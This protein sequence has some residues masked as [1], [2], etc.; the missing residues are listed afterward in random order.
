M[1]RALVLAAGLALALGEVNATADQAPSDPTLKA[2]QQFLEKRVVADPDDIIAQN[3]LADIYLQRLSENGDY[4]WLRRAGEAARRSLASV[5]A[6]QNATGL[7]VQ[8]RV[9]YESHH[10]AAARDLASALIKIEPTKSRGFALLG[11]ALL[12]YGDLEE[13]AA[14][15]E[16]MRERKAAPV[17][18]EA[19]LGHLEVARGGRDAARVH[20]ERAVAAARQLSPVNPE[21][22]AS[23]LVQAGELEFDSGKWE[24]AEKNYEAALAERPAD[25]GALVRLAEL[26]AA[27]AK[28]EEAISLFER[29]ISQKPRPEFWH[30]LGDVFAAAGKPEIAGQWRARAREAYLKNATEG[31]AHYFHH[32]AE[33][34]SDTEPNPEEA[35]K[36]ARRDAELRHTAAVQDALAW[37]LYRGGD[38]KQAVSV[39]TKVL[40][41]GV[42]DAEILAHAGTIFLAAGDSARGNEL[43]VAAARV[44]PRHAEFHVHR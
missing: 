9:E 33:F 39:A 37:A 41:G 13:A 12:E 40:A 24:E 8:A 30:A 35:L 1:C 17:E 10:F 23:C 44:N 34:F 3:R 38:L 27:Q 25:V 28:Y 29:A 31:N 42:K 36:W 11:D 16:K 19:R 7:Y 4:E 43:L 22:T 14:A 5:P 18:I 2:V 20:L 26:R 32:L 21:I 6:Q 15:Y